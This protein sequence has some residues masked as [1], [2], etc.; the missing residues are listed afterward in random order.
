MDCSIAKVADFPDNYHDLDFNIVKNRKNNNHLIPG[1]CFGYFGSSVRYYLYDDENVIKIHDKNDVKELE[2]YRRHDM[3]FVETVNYLKC[4]TTLESTIQRYNMLASKVNRE[5]FNQL[6][7]YLVQLSLNY[8]TK[9]RCTQDFACYTSPEEIDKIFNDCLHHPPTISKYLKGAVYGYGGMC[10]KFNKNLNHPLC[11][12]YT[13]DSQFKNRVLYCLTDP[14]V[15][16]KQICNRMAVNMKGS[17][18]T[19]NDLMEKMELSSDDN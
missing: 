10:S 15:N 16:I 12:L 17:R 14:L 13:Q 1:D 7:Q 9:I 18:K 5:I 8:K 3:P 2:D 4:T 11:S 19:F 6:K